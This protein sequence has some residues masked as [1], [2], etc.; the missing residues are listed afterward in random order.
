MTRRFRRG[1]SRG[2]KNNIWSVILI[3]DLTIA[4]TAI[5]ADIVTLSDIQAAGT[6]FERFTLLR[7]R[8]WIS[9]SKNVAN[10]INS[11]LF[12]AIYTVDTDAAVADPSNANFYTEEDVLWTGGINQVA[13]GAG[14]VESQSPVLMPV[15]VKAMRKIDSGRD[16]RFSAIGS[17]AGG[18]R[19]SAV[20]RGLTRKGGN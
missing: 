14:A 15:D 19:I 6:G 2:P 11:T 4:T 1:V 18:Q 3:E 5:E 13:N 9:V 7:V 12:M 10:Q 16:V 20:F 8:G 17:A